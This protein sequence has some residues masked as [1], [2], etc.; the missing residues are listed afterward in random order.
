MLPNR[1]SWLLERSDTRKGQLEHV[2]FA[3]SFM[4]WYDE[5]RMRSCA[6]WC[7]W[8]TISNRELW[9]GRRWKLGRRIDSR[10]SRTAITYVLIGIEVQT[11][12]Y[13]L[14][15]SDSSV[16]STVNMSLVR[17]AWSPNLKVRKRISAYANDWTGRNFSRADLNTCV[18]ILQLV[19]YSWARHRVRKWSAMNIEC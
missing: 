5:F 14:F 15:C 16:Y 3:T 19:V 7:R 13:V 2:L 9:S 12:C 6:T 18:C 17:E 10:R 8:S 11:C 1:F 4:Y